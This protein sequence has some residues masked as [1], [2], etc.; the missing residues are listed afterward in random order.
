MLFP[1]KHENLE[2]NLLILGSNIISLLKRKDYNIEN[3]FI[4]LKNAKGIELEQFY[5]TITFLWLTEIVEV[6]DFNVYLKAK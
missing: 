3:L 1:A 5:N 6:N 2:R 4:Q